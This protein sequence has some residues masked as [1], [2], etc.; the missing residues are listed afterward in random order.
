MQALWKRERVSNNTLMVVHCDG[1]LDP[2]RIGRVLERFLEFCP[3]P[4]AR[5]RRPFPWGQLHWAAP[6]NAAAEAPAVRHRRLMTPDGLHALLEAELNRAI[7][8]CVEPPL[9][10]AICD[11]IGD[12][13]G[14]QSALVLTWFHPLMDPRGALRLYENAINSSDRSMVDGVGHGQKRFDRR[15]YIADWFMKQL[16]AG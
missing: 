5:L 8:P 4:A 13:A 11:T 16:R 2:A 9:R 3:W 14:P 10:I 7:D 12:G 15:T 6:A 1:P